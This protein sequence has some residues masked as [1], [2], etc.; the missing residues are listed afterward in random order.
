[1]D[2]T[3]KIK[4]AQGAPMFFGNIG[5]G[6]EVDYFVENLSIMVASGMNI[7]GALDA[8]LQEMRSMRMK[9]VIA[10]LKE[11]I[12]NGSSL[13]RALEAANIFSSS[14][15]SLIR[16]GEESGKLS[17]NLKVVAE[18]QE[19]NRI[20]KSKIISAMMYPVFVLSLTL[21]VG[22]GIAWFILPKLAVVFSQLKIQLP[23]VTKI[24]I[25][26][27]I[28]LSRHGQY[29]VPLVAII[30]AIFFYLLF[31]FPK[32]KGIGQALLFGVPGIKQLIKE[33]E[34]ARFGYLLGT[35]MEAGLTINQSLDSLKDAT[36]FSYY[37][38]FYVSLKNNI[39]D[40][41]SFQK[42]FIA[43]KKSKKLVPIPVQQL[44]FAGE[45]SGNL[46]GVL[47]KIGQNYEA[48]ME[49]TT[50]NIVVI[51]EPILLVIVWLGVVAVAL[52]VI[53]PIYSL[54]GGFKAI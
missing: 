16:I 4:S 21:I 29:V 23:L 42:S 47:L 1:M 48:K 19:K 50:K 7:T 45:Q 26:T 44:I 27:G 49:T 37:K 15:V 20:F 51:L 54:I 46:S 12:D 39:E 22:V 10:F 17:Q 41:N 28:F 32:T 34:L 38:K 3:K 33:V 40:G 25:G 5:I 35:L 6:K 11:E 18:Q 36:V 43:Y 30:L 2:K 53:L 13:S 52:A 9:R 14:A 8:I 31:F 24:L